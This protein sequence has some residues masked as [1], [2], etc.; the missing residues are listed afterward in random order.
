VLVWGWYFWEFRLLGGW[1]VSVVF[2]AL[3]LPGTGKKKS[4]PVGPTSRHTD[5]S[6]IM[7]ILDEHFKDKM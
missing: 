1:S 3:L 6:N 2:S 7:G 4:L 5:S